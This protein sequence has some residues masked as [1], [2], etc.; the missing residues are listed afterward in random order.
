MNELLF[1][2][3][4]LIVVAFVLGALRLGKEA[5]IS[6]IALQAVIVNLFV[7]KQITLFGLH[8]TSSDVFSVGG[9][10][11]INLLNEY[12]G[13]A[14]AR[15]SILISFMAMLFFGVMAYIHLVYLPNIFD[16]SQLHFA[17][18]LLPIPRIL[19]ASFIAYFISGQ[20]DVWFYSLL[21]KNIHSLLLCSFISIVTT[22][23]IDTFIFSF[24]GLYGVVESIF[25]II[26]VSLCIKVV[27]IL[28]ATPFNLLSRKIVK[29]V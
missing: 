25:H 24:L 21:K 8:V 3:H 5:L 6:C 17:K 13:K 15:L 20:F 7:L 10:L 11:G 2:I 27:I 12:F 16:S 18:L 23:F 14:T 29:H 22:Q 28:I 4:I 19:A 26:V 1:F 9:I